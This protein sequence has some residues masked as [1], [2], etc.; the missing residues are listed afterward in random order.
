MIIETFWQTRSVRQTV[1]VLAQRGIQIPCRK[2]GQRIRYRPALGRVGFILT[3]RRMRASMS[4]EKA[5]RKA[6]ALYWRAGIQ[7]GLDCPRNT[8]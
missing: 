3:I 8:G 1:K 6:E 2:R 4:M 5:G 7:K